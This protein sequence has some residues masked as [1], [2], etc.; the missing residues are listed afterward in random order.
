MIESSMYQ[1]VSRLPSQNRLEH[2]GKL[3]PLPGQ[4]YR[5]RERCISGH[6]SQDH[7]LKPGFRLGAVPANHR[8]EKRSLQL[9]PGRL[10][11]RC[12]GKP[13]L[14]GPVS[15]YWG[16]VTHLKGSS[17]YRLA[18]TS[19]SPAPVVMGITRHVASNKEPGKCNSPLRE[20]NPLWGLRL[21][22]LEGSKARF[23]RLPTPAR[24]IPPSWRSPR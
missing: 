19:R 9:S 10:P 3:Q 7:Y 21:C 6:L 22:C 2:P 16:L 13:P 11:L 14:I 23:W 17:R 15:D 18:D 8:P 24:Q 1:V 5:L 4:G 12:L 20:R